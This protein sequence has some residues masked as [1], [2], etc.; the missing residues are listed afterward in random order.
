MDFVRVMRLWGWFLVG[1]LGAAAPMFAFADTYSATVQYRWQ[2][3]TVWQSST[4]AAYADYGTPYPCGP[5]GTYV[6]WTFNYP[7]GISHAFPGTGGSA[8]TYVKCSANPNNITW[9]SM[10]RQWTCPYG[11]TLSGTSCINATPCTAPQVRDTV[12]GAC[13]APPEPCAENAGKWWSEGYGWNSGFPV[14]N[15]GS[16]AG[17]GLPD[18]GCVGGCTVTY[19]RSA[20]GYG[21]GRYWMIA[22]A[23]ATGE[24]CTATQPTPP[25]PD[26]GP[27]SPETSPEYDCAKSGQGWGTF[28]GTVICTGPATNQ[29]KTETDKSKTTNP[30]GTT[31]EQTKETT[32]TGGTCTETTTT[33]NCDASGNNCTTSTSTKTGTG[34]SEEDGE[35]E[36][37]WGASCGQEPACSGDAVQ[38]ATAKAVFETN[39]QYK[40][41]DGNT[42]A[43]KMARDEDPALQGNNPLVATETSLDAIDVQATSG[44]CPGDIPLSVMGQSVSIPFAPACGFLGV[45]GQI[46]VG[47]AWLSAF[48]IVQRSIV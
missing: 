47:L 2:G 15:F 20:G 9:S 32:C 18:T 43:D 30:D 45:M 7:T 8:T 3:K 22:S 44:T 10:S 48:W 37:K 1:V 13:V 33:T 4:D 11:G 14:E 41:T 26:T 6:D 12:T 29:T 34:E 36:S 31:T 40:P 39:C 46:L 16:G 17:D 21:S 35:P 24:S 38:C 19:E 23:K 5:N 28:N 42:L 27:K 25:T